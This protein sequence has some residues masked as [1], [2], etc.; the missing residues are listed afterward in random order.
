[1]LLNTSSEYCSSSS[2]K[3]L[4][5]ALSHLTPDASADLDV[6]D[7]V[8][9]YL[10]ASTQHAPSP[11]P[12]ESG[13]AGPRRGVNSPNTIDY[14][15]FVRACVDSLTR[16]V[17]DGVEPPPS[18][19][20]RLD[21]G[22][23]DGRPA[24]GR[25]RRRQRSGWHPPPRRQCPARHL[26]RL[27]PAPPVH[28]RP[29]PARCAPWA[30][31]SPSLPPPSPPATAPAT[32]SSAQIRTAAEALAARA[33][34]AVRRYPRHRLRLRGSMGPIHYSLYPGAGEGSGEASL[35]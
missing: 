2:P 10:C 26:P 29:A 27:E 19:Y 34:P 20:P 7:N 9:V 32:P 5:A 6:P 24:L 31:R 1:M 21:D 30:R 35:A 28:R 14:K 12:L 17:V 4:S 25:R 33:L 15:P 3:H 13:D 23:L 11:L 16:W 8:R 18:V 22:T